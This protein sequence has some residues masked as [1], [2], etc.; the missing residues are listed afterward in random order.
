MNKS[1]FS[2][3]KARFL[4]LSRISVIFLHIGLPTVLVY[5]L[6]VLFSAL[7][8]KDQPPYILAHVYTPALEHII[9]TLTVVIAAAVAAD[10]AE[11]SS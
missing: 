10:I 4:S 2:K 8:T 9:M 11:R 1:V 5:L 3:L 6:G 7:C